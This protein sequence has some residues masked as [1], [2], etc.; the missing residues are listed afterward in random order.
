MEADTVPHA[1][2]RGPDIAAW[3]AVGVA[4]IA[5]AGTA[6]AQVTGFVPL[7][8]YS[9]AGSAALLIAAAAFAAV[10]HGGAAGAARTCEAAFRVAFASEVAARDRLSFARHT[11]AVMASLPQ[12]EGLRAVLDESLTRFSAE[13]AA[14]VG[15]DITMVTGEG[16][17]RQEAQAGVLHVALETVRAGRAVAAEL[18]EDGAT[19]LTIPLRIRGQL[20]NVMVLWRR[21]GAFGPDDLDG[22]S[23]VARIVELSME[24]RALVDEV[25][26]QL[27]GTLHMMV[28]LVEQRLPDYRTHSE[29]AAEYAVALGRAIGMRDDE[30]EDLRLAALLHDVGMLAVPES[31]LNTPRRLTLEEQVEL[32]GHPAHGAELVRLANFGPRVQE[33]VR[34]HHERADGTGY[35]SGLKG[36]AIPLGARVL[37]VCDAFVAMISDRPHRARI[38]VLEALD[39]LRSS[40]G[41]HY[42]ARLVREFVRVQTDVL[43]ANEQIG[44]LAET[45][46]VLIPGV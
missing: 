33:T 11:A 18:E 2:L 38:S 21:G 20:T 17:E 14:I 28:D 24:N 15:E 36:D 39:A 23:L 26:E 13:A 10:R 42:D 1:P 16:V 41:M 30:L 31:I 8:P 12:G 44:A 25:R 37:C 5:T 40:A 27:S 6:F 35:P 7:P 3:A 4:T 46:A 45:P 43:A 29:R 9:T 32:R 22:L 19:A 34:S